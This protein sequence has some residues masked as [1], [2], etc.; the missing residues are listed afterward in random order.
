MEK[1]RYYFISCRSL[2]RYAGFFF[3]GGGE[4]RPTARANS[5]MATAVAATIIPISFQE[6]RARHSKLRYEW[7]TPRP[8]RMNKESQW[9]RER[10]V[11]RYRSG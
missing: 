11:K 7:E 10:V 9:V 5:R 3:G 6:K 2:P 1:T 4:V 8:K